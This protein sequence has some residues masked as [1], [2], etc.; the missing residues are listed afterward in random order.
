MP[1]NVSSQI[2][3]LISAIGAFAGSVT[4]SCSGLPFGASCQFQPSAVTPV[5]GTPVTATLAVST[6]VST[7]LGTSQ[8]TISAFSPGGISKTQTLTLTTSS[9][10]DY[11]LAIANPSLT[12]NVNASAVFNGTLTSFNGYSSVVSLGCGVGAPPSC[13]VAPASAAPTTSGTPFTARVSSSVSQAYSFNITG[14]GS[15]PAAIAHSAAVSFTAMP[16]QGF[17]FTMGITPTSG[18]VP[19]GQSTSFSLSVAP[20]T[21]TFPSNV[22]FACS[23]L[24]A[25]T[26][27]TFSPAQVGAGSG[28]STIGLT[29]STTAPISRSAAVAVIAALPLG[30]LF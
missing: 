13:V 26:A 15:D 2:S 28:N 6:S 20:T 11:G 21:G 29:I 3:L 8:I 4:L 10:P 30:S 23:N 14:V 22:S 5:T 25:M 7:P 17:D 16:A 27:C 12:A 9:A 24:P 18:S 1:G 19:A